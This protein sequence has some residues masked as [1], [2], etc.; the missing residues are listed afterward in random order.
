[1]KK[2]NS[3]WYAVYTKPFWEKKISTLL[4][5]AGVLNYCPV[6]KILR[7][8]SD[9]KKVIYAPLFK[10]YVFINI[11]ESQ[12]TLV[13]Q[14]SGI[15]NFVNYLGQPAVIRDQE[16]EAIKKFHSEHDEIEVRKT[17]ADSNSR[18]KI[19]GA[20]FSKHQSNIVES[21]H[22][23]AELHLPTFGYIL[24]AKLKKTHLHSEPSLVNSNAFTES[25]N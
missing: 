2:T 1:M 9:R 6:Q 11:N 4:E 10:S 24:S 16:I 7:Q 25:M 19:I 5:S 21:G 17:D 8:W 23:K 13:K 15:I 20:A 18:T 22:K 12:K 3:S 14:I